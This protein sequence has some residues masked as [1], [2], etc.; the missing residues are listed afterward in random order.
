[1]AK[2]EMSDKLYK[3]FENFSCIPQKIDF[4]YK[5]Q[6]LITKKSTTDLTD[7]LRKKTVTHFLYFQI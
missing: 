7:I 3:V 1:M 5:K 4:K 2:L 6:K